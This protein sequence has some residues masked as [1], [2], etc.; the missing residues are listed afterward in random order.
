[1][2]GRFHAIS[3]T[4]TLAERLP[5]TAELVE[6]AERLGDPAMRSRAW[7]VRYRGMLEAGD[8]SQAD[9]ALLRFTELAT[10]LNQPALR[11][12][13]AWLQAARHL[14]AGRIEQ[15]EVETDH[16][17]EIGQASGQ[18]DAPVFFHFQRY[19]IRFEQGR[20]DE[21]ADTWPE[22]M[23]RYPRLPAARAMLALLLSEI[24]RRD[25]A[26]DALEPLRTSGFDLPR[27][28]THGHTMAYC[29]AVCSNLGDTT[30]AALLRERLAPFAEQF[31]L[32]GGGIL[33]GVFAHHL[34]RLASTLG[35]R[36]EADTRFAAAE[37]IHERVGTPC[38]LARTRLEWGRMLLARH[39]P[40][41]ADRARELLGQALVTARELGLAKVERDAVVL[42]E[43]CP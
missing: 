37:A 2:I 8:I 42:L 30:A 23:G 32:P 14:M 5:L 29:A 28:H 7:F 9:Q 33:N 40:G 21:L 1:M 12:T 43:V 16:A 20:L 6:L 11:W 27:D 22:V 31:P 18:P 38:W 19:H 35:D 26:R 39:R 41:D 17:F 10:E 24:G 34:G 25:E 15:A 4:H 36:D 3:T 13:A